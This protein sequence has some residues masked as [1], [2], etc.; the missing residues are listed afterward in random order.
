MV[1][2]YNDKLHVF[3]SQDEKNLNKCTE[4]EL[5]SNIFHLL[6]IYYVGLPWWRSG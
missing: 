1:I 3:H 2:T 4:F 5:L 6:R